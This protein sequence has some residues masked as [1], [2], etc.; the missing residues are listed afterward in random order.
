M[1][2]K[3]DAL[4]AFAEEMGCTDEEADAE[5]RRRIKGTL[6]NNGTL[7]PGLRPHQ[8]RLHQYLPGGKRYFI[9]SFERHRVTFIQARDVPGKKGA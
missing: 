7:Y 4:H 6:K 5:I 3:W 8:W 2:I 9:I 1:I